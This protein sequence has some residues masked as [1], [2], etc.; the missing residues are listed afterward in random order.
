MAKLKSDLHVHLDHN[1]N[2]EAVIHVLTK[3]EENGVKALSLLEHNELNLYKQNG[4]LE[5]LIKSGELENYYT[6]KLISGCE[7]S[8]TIN[9]TPLS[10]SGFNFNNYD[11]HLTI[12]GFDIEK[13]EKVKWFT[14]KFQNK[15][16]KK[17]VVTVIKMLKALNLEVPKKKYFTFERYVGKQVY[18]FM[19]E[20][21]QRLQ[22]YQNKLGVYDNASQFVRLTMEDPKGKLYYKQHRVPYVTDVVEYAKKIG[23][24]VFISHPYYMNSK[25]NVYEYL[26]ALLNIETNVKHPFDGIEVPYF[27]NTLFEEKMLTDF[28]I[29][30]NLKM[31]GGTDYQYLISE[32]N[33]QGQMYLKTDAG[34]E[35]FVPVPGTMIKLQKE[36]GNGEL[37]LN[38]NL[39][40]E[41]NDIRIQ[42][43]FIR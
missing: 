39:I 31:S 23:A 19:N 41:L 42:E 30:F 29:K 5:K 11:I 16:F 3:A 32:K 17:D 9:N 26:E 12:L 25:F 33:P 38:E 15:C 24:K 21:P 27:Q 14:K 34:I 6:G 28:A 2:S 10:R 13:A 8:C 18:E 22:S 20:N 37:T 35:Y 4:V 40:N 1:I 36:T 7:I 43:R